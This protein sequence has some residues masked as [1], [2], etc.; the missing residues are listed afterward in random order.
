[1]HAY[2]WYFSSRHTGYPYASLDGHESNRRPQICEE[3]GHQRSFN[4]MVYDV[5]GT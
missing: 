4:E 5:V 3:D 2:R 1:M